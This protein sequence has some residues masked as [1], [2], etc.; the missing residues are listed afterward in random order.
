M[1]SIKRGGNMTK[2]KAV[3]PMFSNSLDLLASILYNPAREKKFFREGPYP[4]T[5]NRHLSE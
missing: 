4:S 2:K 1:Q 5:L 3:Y